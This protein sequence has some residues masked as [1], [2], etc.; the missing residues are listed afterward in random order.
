MAK[1]SMRAQRAAENLCGLISPRGNTPVFLCTQR[2]PSESGR[3]G[4]MG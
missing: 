4:D 3:S 2:V 1:G